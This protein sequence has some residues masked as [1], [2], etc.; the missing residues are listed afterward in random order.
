MKIFI[1][2]VL[3]IHLFLG[4]WFCTWIASEKGIKSRWFVRAGIT[5]STSFV[6]LPLTVALFVFVPVLKSL[7]GGFMDGGLLLT[8]PLFF[9]IFTALYYLVAIGIYKLLVKFGYICYE[10]N[11]YL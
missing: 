6:S 11:S 2:V 4:Y 3:V 10:E 5:L 7:P 8:Y 9:L 1:S